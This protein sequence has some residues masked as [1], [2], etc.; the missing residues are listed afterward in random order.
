MA[1]FL[2]CEDNNKSKFLFMVVLQGWDREVLTNIVNDM[3]MIVISELDEDAG[4]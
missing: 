1:Q 4:Y 2:D 3:F